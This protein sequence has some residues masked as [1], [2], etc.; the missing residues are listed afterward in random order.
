MPKIKNFIDVQKGNC[1]GLA[2]TDLKLIQKK[3]ETHKQELHLFLGF[4]V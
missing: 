4:R 3:V 2:T 1:L